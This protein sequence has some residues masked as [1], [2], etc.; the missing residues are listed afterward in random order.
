V[1]AATSQAS[2]TDSAHSH[3]LAPFTHGHVFDVGN[4]K[5]ERSTLIVLFVTMAMMLVEVTAGWWTGSMALL[6][7]GWHMGTDALGLAVTLFAYWLARRHARDPSYTFGTWKIEVLGSFA[8]ALVLALVAVG[9]FG[10]SALRLWHAE[11][12]N[13][14][15]ALLVTV[16]GLAVNLAC[17]FIL[18]RGGLAHAHHD[19]SAEDHGHAHGDTNE[20]DGHHDHQGHD[21]GHDR[22]EDINLR[23]AYVHVLADALTS[24]LAIGA[25]LGTLTMGW[26]WLDPVMGMVG[27]SIIGVWS[28]K[29]LRKSARVLLDREMDHPLTDQVRQL[30]ES[31]GDAKVADL[32]VWRV[33]RNSF[34]VIVSVVADHPHSPATYR[35]RL[36]KQANVVHVS[37]E[38]N[39]C[40]G[41]DAASH[42]H[43][44]MHGASHNQRLGH[45]HQH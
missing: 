33:G 31:D 36:A 42:G 32:H 45:P 43:N 12:I 15:P 19:H 21:E 7:D 4:R 24:V 27:A 6:A 14:R 40:T 26:S 39:Q 1:S 8:S 37:V 3:D 30:I 18:H 25:L 10:E 13:A 44:H 22:G 38:V 41:A 35:E 2:S 34:S 5:G 28:I 20:H 11:P 23:A 9:I 17:A 16:I 29:L